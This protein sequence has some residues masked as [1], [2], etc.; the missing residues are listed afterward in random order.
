MKINKKFV[1]RKYFGINFAIVQF[2]SNYE[3]GCPKQP[4]SRSLATSATEILSWGISVITVQI[5]QC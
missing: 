2:L 4:N 5:P 3:F 1:K